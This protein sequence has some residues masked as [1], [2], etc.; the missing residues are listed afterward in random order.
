M[1]PLVSYYGGKQKMSSKIVPM[2]PRH[3]VYVEPFAGGAA[4]FFAKPW[5]P[6]TNN[7]RYRE[8]LNDSDQ[9]IVNLYQV[10]RTPGLREQLIERL[11]LTPYA[12]IEHRAAVAQYTDKQKP[13]HEPDQ[14]LYDGLDPRVAKAVAYYVN[15][16]CSFAN[17]LNGGW[18]TGVWSHNL[19]TTWMNKIARLPEYL[20]R[21]SGVIIE[22]DD[23][24]SVIDR[25]DSPQTLFYCDPPYPE[26]RQGY[27]EGTDRGPFNLDD[28]NALCKKLDN[29]QGSFLLSGYDQPTP[30]HWERF[31]FAA[32]S[33]ARGNARVSG[34]LDRS[35][36]SRRTNTKRTEVVWRVDRSDNARTEAHDIWRKW[37]WEKGQPMPAKINDF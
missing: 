4:I 33:T 37:G 1:R 15:V 2:L 22:C 3:T 24:L 14:D 36:V 6:V 27:H 23:A 7:N 32:R 21:M 9:R 35:G 5:P 13:A 29:C 34:V 25:W 17:K 26:T 19:G 28:W 16:Q 8:V 20:D 12:R 11:Q 18:G 10:I 30:D 31:D